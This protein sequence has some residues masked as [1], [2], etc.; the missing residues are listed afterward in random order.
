[1]AQFD[2]QTKTDHKKVVNGLTSLVSHDDMVN[3]FK[4]L[5]FR[6]CYA[7][8][9][10]KPNWY[11][12]SKCSIHRKYLVENLQAI[13]K[14]LHTIIQNG[15]LLNEWN[16]YNA[17]RTKIKNI[18][19]E[20]LKCEMKFCRQN[21]V[22]QHFWKLLY[23]NMIESTRRLATDTTNQHF[24]CYKSM[25]LDVIDDG[26]QF[27]GN[28]L[29]Q[30]S[31]IYNY[32]MD[33]FLGENSGKNLKGLKYISLA[34]VS[35]QK[36]CMNMGDLLRY[37]ELISE[38]INFEEAKQWYVKAYQLIPSNGMPSNQLAI[39]A[40]YNKRKFDAIFYHMRSLNASNPI[41]SAKESLVI[42][43]D[44]LHKKYK[45][46][47][48]QK[49]N[50]KREP[51]KKVGE[52]FKRE[53][54]VHPKDG[55]L[56]YRTVFLDQDNSASDSNDLYKKFIF[57]YSHFHGILFTR[58]G[59]DKLE[60][61]ME[62]NLKQ[63]Q[64]L[65]NH[66]TSGAFSFQKMIQMVLINIFAIEN[67]NQSTPVS[68]ASSLLQY[69]LV[70]AFT[71]IGI[72]LNKL[73]NEMNELLATGNNDSFEIKYQ[74]NDDIQYNIK[75]INK[76][77]LSDSINNSLATASLWCNWMKYSLPI[78]HSNSILRSIHEFSET[79]R[80]C[81]WDEF[82][83]LT[84][85]LNRFNFETVDFLIIDSVSNVHCDESYKRCRLPEEMLTLCTPNLSQNDRF[86]CKQTDETSNICSFVRLKNIFIFC[87]NDLI[88]GDRPLL[89][90]HLS[91]KFVATN[92]CSF[93]KTKNQS[94]TNESTENVLSSSV[95]YDLSE[96]Q[97]T[98]TDFPNPNIP[99][100]T[101]N[102]VES[103]EEIQKLLQRKNELE[104][105]HK[106]HEKLDQYTQEILRQNNAETLSI[107]VRPK[108]LIP[109]TNCFIDFLQEI[110]LLTTVY[111]LYHVIVP[112]VVLNEL[113]GLAKG[114]EG[115]A[116]IY[117]TPTKTS[118]SS[119]K[120]LLF[121]KNAGTVI[122]CATTKGSFLNSMAFTKESDTTTGNTLAAEHLNNDDKILLTVAN[123]TKIHSENPLQKTLTNIQRKVVLLTN[124]RNLKLKAITQNI[125][126]RELVDFI[127]WSGITSQSK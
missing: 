24:Q 122:K 74:S 47:E 42:L 115:G 37:K 50:N 28:L 127:K 4:Q 72:I 17:S 21:N 45:S 117:D 68:G 94:A 14:Q 11:N 3:A 43:F 18:F 123:L 56:N 96:A 99:D 29:Q 78:W 84:T 90:K 91:G 87:S 111:P 57:N 108:Y 114:D 62:Q 107:E 34:I 95:Q 105:S 77:N 82:A 30:L 60:L 8:S 27:Y 49:N 66:R 48:A 102:A 12:L 58:V 69:A 75:N 104:Q 100:T 80:I 112:I 113:E 65:L 32:E 89:Q 97:G 53:I 63:F 88:T 81:I 9:A 119:Q 121:L 110:R 93:D 109:D 70:F 67:C 7:Q 98:S 54:W 124:D 85:V 5:K 22:E 103:S 61:C 6:E 35:A 25:S 20:L 31:Q 13:D 76:F 10:T 1:M 120:A 19:T 118:R 86:Y 2:E 55:Q 51:N 79:Y 26:I 33:D 15:Q 106:M 92:I 126:V 39:L 83:K 40:L 36:F 59:A 41:K 46:L 23:Y 38:T 71:F 125:P 73:I 44:E 16:E 64:E 52:K 101:V 116:K